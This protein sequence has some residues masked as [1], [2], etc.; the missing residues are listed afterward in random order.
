M[1]NEKYYYESCI[2]AL[3]QKGYDYEKAKDIV[4]FAPLTAK[5]RSG[6]NQEYF[7]NMDVNDWI[8]IILGKGNFNEH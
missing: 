7:N 2:H 4:E 1:T 8:E 5:I 3:M 6:D